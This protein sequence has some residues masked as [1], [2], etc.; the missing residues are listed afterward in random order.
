MSEAT[1]TLIARLRRN[2]GPLATAAADCIEALLLEVAKL[3]R[4]P[5]KTRDLH[6]LRRRLILLFQSRIM[7]ATRDRREDTAWARIAKIV[8]E[9]DVAA[10]ERFYRAREATDSDETWS[11]KKNILTLL[12]QYVTQVELAHTW[13]D[14]RRG[15]AAGPRAAKPAIP[16]PEGWQARA[17]GALGERSWDYVC[18]F[19]PEE[20]AQLAQEGGNDE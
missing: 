8:K 14:K 6:P 16:E 5:S 20:A 1:Q 2:G 4:P 11:R 10:L 3:Q 7:S 19:Y 12:N 9:E 17:V 13:A 18:R 15:G